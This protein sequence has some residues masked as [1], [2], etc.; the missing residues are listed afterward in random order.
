MLN[1]NVGPKGRATVLFLNKIPILRSFVWVKELQ[2]SNLIYWHN[3]SIL[4]FF[5]R[6]I[7]RFNY[8]MESDV[9]L[10]R[11]IDDQIQAVEDLV[12]LGKIAPLKKECA[13]IEVGCN[14][15]NLLRGG[16]GCLYSQTRFISGSPAS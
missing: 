11:N 14:V 15:G 8:S 12:K 7:L 6:P 9:Y 3:R 10:G 5:G 16:P 2:I 13:I 4:H 1:F